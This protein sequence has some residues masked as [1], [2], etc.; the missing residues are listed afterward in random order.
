M[1][2][3]KLA[4]DNFAVSYIIIEISA[5]RNFNQVAGLKQL[6]ACVRFKVRILLRRSLEVFPQVSQII[7][8][9]LPLRLRS[10]TNSSSFVIT[11]AFLSLP[12]KNI[13]LSSASCR[14]RNLAEQHPI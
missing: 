10:E 5:P 7:L 6:R 14:S 2:I 13:C 4:N 8:G 12:T 11:V 9:G 3:R 1:Q